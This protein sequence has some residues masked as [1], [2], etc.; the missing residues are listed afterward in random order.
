MPALVITVDEY[1]ERAGEAPEAMSGTGSVARIGR[2][3]AVGTTRPVTQPSPHRDPGVISSPPGPEP[4]G[5]R[6]PPAGSSPLRTHAIIDFT[7]ALAGSA[8]RRFR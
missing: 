7:G 3:V 6:P 2:A 4:P 1:A 8:A 5:R